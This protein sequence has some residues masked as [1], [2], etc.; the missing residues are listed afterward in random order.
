MRKGEFK[1]KGT[2]QV[3]GGGGF[4]HVAITVHDIDATVKFY[5]EVLGFKVAIS[6]GEG[7]KRAAMLDAGDGSCLEV[8]AGGT[9]DKKPEG[10][11]KHL[12]LRTADT[13]TVF[14]RVKA[15]GMEI[16]MQPTDIVIG[17]NPP[18]PAKIAFFKGPDGEIVELFQNK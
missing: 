18:T 4:H 16:T 7:D 13:D 3:L 12:A 9:P 6:W 15:A 14:E 1:M 2:N 10:A 5:T 17:S 8:F 11:F